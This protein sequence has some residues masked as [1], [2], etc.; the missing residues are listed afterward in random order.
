MD[1]VAYK[2]QVFICHSSECWKPEN[3]GPAWLGSDEVPLPV[4]D[5]LLPLS[6]HIGETEGTSPGA[7]LLGH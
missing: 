7:L 4:A 6:S 5:C 2:Q 1:W 3:R